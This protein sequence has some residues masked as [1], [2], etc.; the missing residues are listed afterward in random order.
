MS[1]PF[2]FNGLETKQFDR[3]SNNINNFNLN[4]SHPL[5]PNSNEYIL[6]KKF[7]SI[8]S[9]DRDTIKFPIS[10]EF[11]IE[12]PEDLLNVAALNLIDWSFPSNY[13][14][15]SFENG[16]I[17]LVFKINNP[18]NPG[19][20][21]VVNDYAY[22][23][24]EAL[25]TSQ[26]EN[27]IIQ[28]EPGF[29]NP[30]QL[31]TELTNKMNYAV[32]VRIGEYFLAQGWDITYKEFVLKR[33]YQR[34][35]VVYN[36]VSSRI[37]FGNNVDPFILQNEISTAISLFTNGINCTEF[38]QQL[39]DTSN[40]GLPGNLGLPRCQTSSVNTPVPGNSNASFAYYNGIIV[41]RFYYSDVF[42]GDDGYWLLPDQDLSGS[43]VNWVEATYKINL[44]GDAYMYMEIE[45]QNCIDETKPF[46][47]S[48][49][50]LTTNQTNGV[51]NSAFAKIKIPTTPISQWF[52]WNSIPHKIYNPPAERIRR[53]KIRLRYHNGALV[54]FGVF[55]YSFTLQFTLM[56]PQILRNTNSY[57]YPPVRNFL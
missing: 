50:T 56:V 32:T 13:D 8:H 53:L 48:T 16:N 17:T 22:R 28:I 23:I 54:D 24:Y 34:F 38:K 6:Y 25:F 52:D 2:N 12:L 3:N 37:W 4:T 35:N 42:P 14:V 33:G 15:F 47:V 29:Y 9:E 39:P 30:Q 26:D 40:W 11:E 19:E 51:V 55:N 41:P 31:V 45:G 21:G 44:M 10:S 57:L 18:Y 36:N 5:I 20:Y 49:F 7:V 46:N 43:S 1:V 27:Y